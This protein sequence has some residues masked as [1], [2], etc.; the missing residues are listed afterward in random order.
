MQSKSRYTV[1]NLWS[2]TSILLVQLQIL[3]RMYTYVGLNAHFYVLK[4]CTT[5]EN[6]S[7][8]LPSETLTVLYWKRKKDGE[9]GV[10]AMNFRAWPQTSLRL[11]RDLGKKGAATS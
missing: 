6:E 11:A 9:L 2:F 7:Q 10:C 5:T 1:K 4:L 3:M 8:S